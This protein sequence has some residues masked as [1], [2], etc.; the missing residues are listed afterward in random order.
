MRSKVQELYL[1]RIGYLHKFTPRKIQ[2]SRSHLFAK[3]P[4]LLLAECKQK[5][6]TGA[7]K[8]C[9]LPNVLA[10]SDT[11][12]FKKKLDMIWVNFISGPD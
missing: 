5:S 10:V 1:K 8:I 12:W 9:D 6:Q 2:E 3:L 4:T 7:D 11:I